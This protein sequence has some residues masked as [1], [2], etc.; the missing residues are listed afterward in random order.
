M[1]DG[2]AAVHGRR[3]PNCQRS[4]SRSSPRI[5]IT[6]LQIFVKDHG[7]WLINPSTIQLHCR[8]AISVRWRGCALSHPST[9]G[10]VRIRR[11]WVLPLVLTRAIDIWAIAKALR[12][13][14]KGSQRERM[15]AFASAKSLPGYSCDTV[16]S[17]MIDS[18][19]H[20]ALYLSR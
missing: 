10:K 20:K 14:P 5:W 19:G 3:L 9:V 2:S 4:T 15:P 8:E 12:L 6:F 1:K 13:V 18:L 16:A 17:T 7:P 11:F